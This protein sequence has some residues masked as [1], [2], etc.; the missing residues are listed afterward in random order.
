MSCDPEDGVCKCGG[1]GGEVCETTQVCVNGSGATACR[2]PCEPFADDC[3]ETLACVYDEAA[4]VTFCAPPGSRSIGDV[5]DAMQG[6]AEGLHCHVE[7][8]HSTG[9]CRRYCL[10]TEGCGVGEACRA[11]RPG[12]PLGVCQPV[13]K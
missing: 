5:C 7:E 3:G 11:F 2:T 12:D 1:H 10:S 6:C 4:S 13:A 9:T 8:G